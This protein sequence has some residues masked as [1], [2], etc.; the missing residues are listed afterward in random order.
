MDN[1]MIINF[2]F[3]S[4]LTNTYLNIITIH[5]YG[6]QKWITIAHIAKNHETL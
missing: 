2:I 6:T 5:Y 3:S 4:H 1:K